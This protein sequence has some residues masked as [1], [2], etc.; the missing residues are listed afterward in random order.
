[1]SNFEFEVLQQFGTTWKV[2]SFFFF[3]NHST[4]LY[5]YGLTLDDILAE[6]WVHVLAEP[7]VENGHAGSSQTLGM[8]VTK[9]CKHEILNRLWIDLNTKKG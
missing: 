7:L 2:S 9:G 6:G 3:K 8:D 4:L 5:Y 1:M